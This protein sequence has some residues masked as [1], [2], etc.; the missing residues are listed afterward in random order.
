[1]PWRRTPTAARDNH[2]NSWNNNGWTGPCITNHQLPYT[3]PC[4]TASSQAEISLHHLT[5]LRH[6]G[7]ARSADRARGSRP[8]PRGA[9]TN[10]WCPPNTMQP[11]PPTPRNR[12]S[13]VRAK[14]PHMHGDLALCVSRTKLLVYLRP[15]TH[16]PSSAS[17]T[18]TPEQPY[19]QGKPGPDPQ[20]P[21]QPLCARWHPAVEIGHHTAPNCGAKQ[22]CRSQHP[23]GI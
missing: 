8:Q 7:D 9:T 13:P 19:V 10:T 14:S 22:P 12:Q 15:Q 16:R 3:P 5:Q 23:S 6:R 21:T 11:I 17:S 20:P 1:V 4:G 18:S 2:N